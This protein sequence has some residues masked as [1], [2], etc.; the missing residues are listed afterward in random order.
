MFVKGIMDGISIEW[1]IAGDRIFSGSFTSLV[2]DTESNLRCFA[3][4]DMNHER[5]NYND[6]IFHQQSCFLFCCLFGIL[7]KKCRKTDEETYSSSLKKYHLYRKG[8][9]TR[10]SSWNKNWV[11]EMRSRWYGIRK[12]GFDWF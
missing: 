11:S 5:F 9:V 3:R 2:Q 1:K 8:I 6:L 7:W 10:R 12:K 4:S